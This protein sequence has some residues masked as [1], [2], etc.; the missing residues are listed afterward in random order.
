MQIA[1]CL[2]NAS[3]VEARG[4]IVKVPLV[5]ENRPQF[6]PETGLHEHVQILPVL[7][8]L[9]EFHYEVA[10][11]LAHDPLLRHDVLLLSGLND[12][13]LLHLLQGERARTVAGYLNQLDSAKATHAQRSQRAQ[14]LQSQITELFVQPRFREK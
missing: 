3:R 5:P 13:G 1:K 2:Y 7:E 9:E 4:R 11:G 10:V 12:L 14:I 8:S 6:A